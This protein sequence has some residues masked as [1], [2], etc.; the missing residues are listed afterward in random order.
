MVEAA[1]TTTTLDD[2]DSS[3]FTFASAWNSI[4]P[5]DPCHGCTVKLDS[6]QVLD[7]TWHDGS[8]GGSTALL[9]FEGTIVDE[10]FFSRGQFRDSLGI[11]IQLVTYQ[12]PV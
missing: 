8:V 10:F 11:Q 7:G 6:S 2:G 4:T 5:S 12:V 1:T 3:V 9:E